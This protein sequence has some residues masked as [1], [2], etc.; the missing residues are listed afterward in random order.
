MSMHADLFTWAKHDSTRGGLTG[1]TR[2]GLGGNRGHTICGALSGAGDVA[3]EQFVHLH[4]HITRAPGRIDR[5]DPEPAI[6]SAS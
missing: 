3:R 5:I 1:L 6:L 2:T 4:E